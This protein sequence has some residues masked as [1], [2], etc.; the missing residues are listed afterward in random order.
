LWDLPAAEVAQK[1]GV[2]LVKPQAP[3]EDE[4]QLDELQQQPEQQSTDTEE[5][6]SNKTKRA[7]LV[8]LIASYEKVVEV[9][10]EAGDPE[11]M[12]QIACFKVKIEATKT[13]ITALRPLASQLQTLMK[14]R[15]AMQSKCTEAE[16]RLHIYRQILEHTQ[17]SL[18]KLDTSIARVQEQMEAQDEDKQNTPATEAAAGN[19]AQMLLGQLLEAIKRQDQGAVQTLVMAADLQQRL[20]QAQQVPVHEEPAPPAL[21]VQAP[22]AVDQQLQLAR[23]VA[24]GEQQQAAA[25]LEQQKLAAAA[26]LEQQ[27]QAAAI[28][29]Q[30]KQQQEKVA[31]ARKQVEEAE[32]A[33]GVRRERSN[34]PG[35]ATIR[36]LAAKRKSEQE[37]TPATTTSLDTSAPGSP[38]AEEQ[39]F[40]HPSSLEAAFLADMVQENDQ[41][42]AEARAFEGP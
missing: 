20:T 3:V 42:L 26:L 39:E 37:L 24:L 2:A 4:M 35:R 14:A 29:E 33:A 13:Q 6:K 36:S 30:Q 7:A 12:E 15:K 1:L 28:A 32:Q 23:T 10:A 22:A 8:K 11:S 41:L 21:Q 9:L 16:N 34:S 40:L 25:L 18:A 27:K 19:A 5:G 17:T 38:A 31:A